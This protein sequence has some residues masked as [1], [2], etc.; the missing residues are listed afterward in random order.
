MKLK[1]AFQ[2]LSCQT[3]YLKKKNQNRHE[4]ICK[5]LV[6]QNYRYENPNVLTIHL[7]NL[8]KKKN[9]EFYKKNLIEYLLIMFFLQTKQLSIEIQLE[10]KDG[11]F[12]TKAMI[13][14]QWN[15]T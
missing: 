1:I 15:Q 14:L 2:P 9:I 11:L 8:L 3:K 4:A 7:S 6:S 12:Q 10:I 5:Y 13:S